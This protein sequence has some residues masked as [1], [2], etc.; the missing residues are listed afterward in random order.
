MSRRVT[1]HDLYR[2]HLDEYAERWA[3]FA[4]YKRE[5]GILE[6]RLHT[7][8]GPFRWCDEAHRALPAMFEDLRWDT[9]TECII[10]TGTG[11]SFISEFDHER[12]AKRFLGQQFGPQHAYDGWWI[13]QNREV[14]A[15]LDIPVPVISAVNGP[16]NIHLE[17]SLTNDIVIA[18]DTFYVAAQHFPSGI[19]PGDGFQTIFRELVGHQRANYLM[20]TGR[21]IDAEEALGLG[22]ISEVLP[23]DELLDRAWEIA[24]TM[25]MPVNRVHRRLTRSLLVQPWRELFTAELGRGLAYESWACQSYFPPTAEERDFGGG[26]DASDLLGHRPGRGTEA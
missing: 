17:L 14:F 5:R 16:H 13:S 19:V 22:L 18:A 20:Y 8:D 10:L 21:T 3:E 9:D 26:L 2:T 11:D 4:H 6:I 1:R 7:D 25:F 15:L 12:W 23:H 24:E